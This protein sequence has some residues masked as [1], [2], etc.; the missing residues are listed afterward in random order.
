LRDQPAMPGQQG[1]GRDNRRYFLEKLP[2]QSL[3][4]GSQSAALVIVEA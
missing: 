3:G 2:P 1:L 4:L